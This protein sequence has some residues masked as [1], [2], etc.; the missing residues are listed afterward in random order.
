[1]L[2]PSINTL[3]SN[4]DNRYLLV[5]I[6]SKRAREIADEAEMR[7]EEL[8]IK[9]VSAAIEEIAEGKLSGRLINGPE[10]IVEK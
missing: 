5:N 6:A 7:G 8:E 4:I 2:Y 10:T 9:P 3:L 1:M